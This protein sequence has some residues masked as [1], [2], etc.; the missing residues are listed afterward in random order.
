MP[1]VPVGSG[2]IFREEKT[3]KGEQP[4]EIEPLP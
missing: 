4:E 2:A 3:K 1:A